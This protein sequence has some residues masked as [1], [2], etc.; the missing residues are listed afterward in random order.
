MEDDC[1]FDLS[2]FFDGIPH[3]RCL[4]SLNA[5][6]VVEV[7]KIYRWIQAWLGA[8]G[9][10]Q[11]EGARRQEMEQGG[12]RQEEEQEAEQGVRS[13]DVEQGSRSQGMEQ[14]AR[15][16]EQEAPLKLLRRRQKVIL[17]GQ[18]SEW[19]D[20]TASIVQGSCLGPTLAE[21]FSNNIHQGRNLV[22]EDKPLVSKFEDDEKRCR[23]VNQ[24]V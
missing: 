7:G 3:Q 16:L 22:P 11:E 15:R 10:V 5:H 12:R 14:G 19:H 4:A 13:Q 2:A 23:V 6:G 18:A 1:Y 17:N 20:V 8:G 21:C 24:E 9:E